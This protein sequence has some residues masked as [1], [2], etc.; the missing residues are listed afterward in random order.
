MFWIV[1]ISLFPKKIRRGDSA[2]LWLLV[3]GHS[4]KQPI[5]VFQAEKD[6]I[7]GIGLQLLSGLE[8]KIQIRD[9]RKYDGYC[10]SVCSCVPV[11]AHSVTTGHHDP[12]LLSQAGVCVVVLCMNLLLLLLQRQMDSTIFSFIW[13]LLMKESKPRLLLAKLSEKKFPGCKCQWQC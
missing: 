9:C 10:L 3:M 4:R 5:Y 2:A 8:E 6:L 7:Q 1:K 11:L 13:E 12:V